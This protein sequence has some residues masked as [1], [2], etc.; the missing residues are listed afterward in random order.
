MCAR[1]EQTRETVCEGTLQT[2]KH[3][4]YMLLL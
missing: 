3:T 2:I 1:P 4:H